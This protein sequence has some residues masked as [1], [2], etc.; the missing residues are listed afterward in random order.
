M[1]SHIQQ[2]INHMSMVR[3]AI[4]NVSIGK[5]LQTFAR[6]VRALETPHHFHVPGTFAK[7]MP[8]LYT[9]A[10]H[11]IR[12]TAVTADFLDG[13]THCLGSFL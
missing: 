10:H 4:N 11:S 2:I 13:D 5:T 1:L 7:P 3:Y 6:K 12:E 9:G 8:T